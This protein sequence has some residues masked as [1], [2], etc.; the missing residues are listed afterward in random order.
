M[1]TNEH[2]RLKVLL[3]CYACNPFYGSEP[4]TGWNFLTQIAKHHDVHAIVEEEVGKDDLLRYQQQHPEELKNV[5]FHFIKRRRFRLLRKIW[6]P[7]YYWSYRF[8][9]K[10]AYNLA[11]KLDAVENFDLV[12]QITLVGYREPGYLWKLGKPFIWG[13]LG[14][15][16]QTAWRLL[17]GVSIYDILYFGFRN[18][19][20]SLHKHLN[21]NAKRAAAAAHSILISDP[22][23]VEE[24][25]KLWK[26]EPITMREVGTS[27]HELLT[28]LI[29]KH[30]QGS[31]LRICWSG[32]LIPRK[33]LDLLIRAIALCRHSMQL[34]IIG[35]GPKEKAWK[36]L[37]EKLGVAEKVHFHGYIEHN[38]VASFM[39]SC[40]VFC[41]TSIQ[42]GGTPTVALEALQNG[43]PMITL[44]HC[45]YA[46]V[47]DSTCGYTIPISSRKQIIE[48]IAKHL[49]TLAQNESLRTELARGALKRSRNFTWESKMV[50]LNKI[51]EVAT[52]NNPDL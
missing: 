30:S 16:S 48:D 44:N 25:R 49:D 29:S 6:P 22:M 32:Y 9:Q 11:K 13:P 46:S 12:H 15:F 24:I 1:E 19:L 31:P 10:K 35:K 45:A 8:W 33:A 40:H 3:G 23:I 2:K 42:E 38:E 7:S 27:C 52:K 36:K 21:Y 51:Y 26:K 34:E 4:G 18:I 20:N 43:L 47:V 37:A 28:G 14:G 39:A 50:T 41:I 5:T 17:S